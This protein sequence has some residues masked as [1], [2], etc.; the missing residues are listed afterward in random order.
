MG[1]AEIIY[2][3]TWYNV[4]NADE[5]YWIT[6]ESRTFIVRSGYYEDGTAI[7][8]ALSRDTSLKFFYNEATGRFSLT[9]QSEDFAMSEDLQRRSE[10][11]RVGKECRL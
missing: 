11:R 6:Q 5:K 7:A 10:E 3:H 1:L 8:T 2:P 4:D 9:A